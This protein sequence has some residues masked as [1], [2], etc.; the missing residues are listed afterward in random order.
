MK[1]VRQIGIIMLVTFLGEITKQL[2]DFPIPASIYG[3][4]FMLFFLMTKII[5]IENVKETGSFLIEIMPIA[6]IPATVGIITLWDQLKAMLVPL[7]VISIVTT[8]I[9]MVVSGSVVQFI[10]ERKNRNERDSE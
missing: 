3:L 1:Y 10:V 8:I 4:C 6:L 5:K 9:V 2:L 7:L